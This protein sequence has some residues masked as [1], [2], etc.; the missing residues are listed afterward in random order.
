M[1]QR[2]EESD[3]CVTVNSSS[4]N[5]IGFAVFFLSNSDIVKTV[6]HIYHGIH[7]HLLQLLLLMYNHNKL[8]EAKDSNSVK[9]LE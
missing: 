6:T 4:L 5:E 2:S 9:K 8:I 3:L 1:N 7:F